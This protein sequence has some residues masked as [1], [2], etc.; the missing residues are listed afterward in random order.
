MDVEKIR[1]KLTSLKVQIAEIE[2]L[3]NGE[4]ISVATPESIRGP[5]Y[6]IDPTT[7][8]LH[9]LK[10]KW[11]QKSYIKAHCDELLKP[12]VLRSAI[13]KTR[14]SAPQRSLK[15]GF[16][17][18][19]EARTPIHLISSGTERWMEAQ[20]YKLCDI[21][22]C[23]AA[24]CSLWRGICARQVP[25]Y[26]AA[27]KGGWGEIDLLA[28]ANGGHPI[29]IE[30]KL[31][32]AGNSEAPQRPLFEGAA[33]AVALKKSWNSFWPQWDS[34]LTGIE[35]NSQEVCKAQQVDVILLAPDAY[36][37]YWLKQPQY[38]DAQKSYRS[39]VSQFADEGVKVQFGGIKLAEDGK[40]SEVHDRSDFLG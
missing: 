7:L 38:R 35:F 29:V 33:Y 4:D 19:D 30:L 31:H 2:L 34:V 8:G 18:P 3:L 37:D 6:G 20:L 10:D 17:I 13:E 22:D 23:N 24:K 40:P 28:V 32:K 21:S 11:C 25:I 16:L 1:Q 14:N 27:V 5:F 15:Q 9:I 26:E 12:G 36:W 39:L